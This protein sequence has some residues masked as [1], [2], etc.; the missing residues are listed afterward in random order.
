M[1]KEYKN[2]TKMSQMKIK[3][4]PHT[5]GRWVRVDEEDP[6]LIWSVSR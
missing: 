1:T 5:K 6:V 2:R 3:I 4:T